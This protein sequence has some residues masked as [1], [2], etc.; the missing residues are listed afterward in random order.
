[1]GDGESLQN[2]AYA[3]LNCHMFLGDEGM[4]VSRTVV[5]ATKSLNS[6]ILAALMTVTGFAQQAPQQSN[7]SSAEPQEVSPM[8]QAPAPQH[9]AHPYSELDYTKGQSSFPKFWQP[10]MPRDVPKPN[11]T[12]SAMIDSILKDGKMYLSL[13]DAVSLS[14]ENNLDI[15]IQRYNLDTADTD[16][17][18]TASGAIGTRCKRRSCTGNS[19]RHHGQRSHRRYRNYNHRYD[20]RRRWR[21][22]GCRGRRRRRCCRASCPRRLAKAR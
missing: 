16:I 8:P 4:S 6:L 12:N 11:L 18:R 2:K 5:S 17:L 3:V 9:N 14:L 15:A 20:R 13:N 1:M 22:F 10:Y 21:R 19:R 7:Q